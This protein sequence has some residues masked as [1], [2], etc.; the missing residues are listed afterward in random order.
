[1]EEDDMPTVRAT[2]LALGALA[3]LA[4][5]GARSAE[6]GCGCAKPP[7][8]PA[9]VRPNVTYGGMPV[10]LFGSS[11]Q[12]SQSY[13]VIFTSVFKPGGGTVQASVTGT[14]RARRDLA[15]AVS[16]TQLVVTLPASLPLGP[17]SISVKNASG[18]QVLAVSDSAFT[19]APQPL[20]VPSAYGRYYWSNYQAAVGRDGVVHI[21]LDLSAVQN[22]IVFEAQALGYALRFGSGDI[23]FHNTQGFLMQLLVQNTAQPIPG[24]FA[25]PS[26][27]STDSDML[28]YSR[29]EFDT[30]FLQHQERQPHAVDATDGNW[31]QDGTRHVD[32]DHL[33]LS[34]AGRLPNGSLPTPGA[35]ARCGLTTA[36]LSLFYQGLVGTDAIGMSDNAATDSYDPYS[37]A[38]DVHGDVYTNGNLTVMKSAIVA[39]DASAGSFSV[40]S[41]PGVTGTRT[42]VSQPTTFMDV[43]VPTGLPSLGSIRVTG[44]TPMSLQG[45]GSFQVADLDLNGG[46]LYVDNSAGPVT[47]YVTGTMSVTSGGTVTLADAN[48]EKFAVYVASANPVTMQG[49]ATAFNGVVYAP[50]SQV[51]VTSRGEFFGAF[52]GKTMHVDKWATVHYWNALRAPKK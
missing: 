24:M 14:A 47:L 18:T 46:D 27:T 17:A 34:I 28:H 6:A 19:V 12:A 4:A 26:P 40:S 11:L 3:L 1:M 20:A 25:F 52:L 48:P 43:K 33:I 30:Y 23:V 7:P 41:S 16:K 22:P 37:G 5:F 10:T 36:V 32:H 21:A 35:T 39:G 42:T 29:H 44:C 45:P 38:F 8:P 31:H 9:A 51:Y 2:T 50:Y 15:D 13:T 49:G